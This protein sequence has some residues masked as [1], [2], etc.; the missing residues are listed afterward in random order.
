MISAKRKRYQK[1][2]SST[3]D[4][5][6]LIRLVRENPAL[7]NY[8]LDPYQ[9]R[10]SDI[11]TGW[12]K[13][14]NQLGAKYTVEE[15]R[16]KWKNLRDTYHQYRLRKQN[17]G[18]D[19][20]KWRYATELQFL[21][22]I[23][24]P[25][26]KVNRQQN[27]INKC[28]MLQTTTHSSTENAD[29]T[30]IVL[31]GILM[32][33]DEHDTK[34]LEHIHSDN[35]MGHLKLN[36]NDFAVEIV[37]TDPL[38]DDDCV[39]A[40]MEPS[41]EEVCLYEESGNASMDCETIIGG[42]NETASTSQY[43]DAHDFC[44]DSMNVH[45]LRASSNDNSNMLSNNISPTKIRTADFKCL[46]EINSS[47]SIKQITNATISTTMNEEETSSSLSAKDH[48]QNE[49][50]EEL[51]LF[52][53]FLKKKIQHFSKDR[54]TAIQVEFLNCVLKHEEKKYRNK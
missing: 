23:Y 17:G 45:T 11:L 29:N 30:K 3:D 34:V 2:S 15:C 13:I 7:Y 35:N 33:Y 21:S 50:N 1:S 12:T 51:D 36:Q 49:T 24:Q 26:L 6:T 40:A 14:A 4:T 28:G 22:T 42:H 18:N 9:R 48:Q 52:F 20:S 25:K 41:Y 38:V 32:T 5:L 44:I 37:K 10:R 16:R 53:D 27:Y 43:V 46:S 54:I 31:D 19:F 47:S 8:K 39:T